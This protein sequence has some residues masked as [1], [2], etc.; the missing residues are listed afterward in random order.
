MPAQEPD[1]KKAYV[2]LRD[3]HGAQRPRYWRV[4]DQLRPEAI[5]AWPA[6]P[7]HALE[8][9]RKRPPH[10]WSAKGPRRPDE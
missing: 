7:E 3:E 1:Y 5:E 4:E 9:I 10:D 6:K 2:Y 8:A